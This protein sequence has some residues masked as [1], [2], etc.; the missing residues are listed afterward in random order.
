[1][2]KVGRY[3]YPRITID[4]ALGYVEKFVEKCPKGE[5]SRETFAKYVLGHSPTS[6]TT[7]QLIASIGYYNLIRSE[8][9]KILITD[10]G[11]RAVAGVTE[12]D[13]VRAVVEALKRVDLIRD[14]W[15]EHGETVDGDVVRIF[16]K[17]TGDADEIEAARCTPVVTKILRSAVKWLVREREMVVKERERV[18]EIP[19]IPTRAPSLGMVM[20]TLPEGVQ[21]IVVSRDY[22]TIYIRDAASSLEILRKVF[23]VLGKGLQQVEA[24]AEKEA[25]RSE[26]G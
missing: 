9:G 15:K 13:R 14:Y 2:P 18:E 16:L 6:S 7:G 21:M 3:S 10:L 23:E 17:E 22:G 8:K 4:E 12:K 1:M 19:E 24:R 20:P 25:K 26:R 5:M 11:K